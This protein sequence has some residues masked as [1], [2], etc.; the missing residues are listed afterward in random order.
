MRLADLSFFIT[1]LPQASM[2]KDMKGNAGKKLSIRVH[3]EEVSK[4][5][6]YNTVNDP[7][8]ETFIV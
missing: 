6:S 5:A 1:L 2:E 4:I 3:I 8:L 7:V